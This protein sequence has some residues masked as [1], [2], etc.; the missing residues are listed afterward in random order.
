MQ[1]PFILLCGEDRY[2]GSMFHGRCRRHLLRAGFTLIEL[3]LV[4]GIIAVLAAITISAVNPTKSIGSARDT[5]RK[6]AASEIRKA[7]DQYL[8]ATSALPNSS[9][10]PVGSTLA[11]PICTQGVTTDATCINMDVLAPTYIASIPR[12]STEATANYSG[13]MVYKDSS[14]RP[15]VM[16]A[17]F[18]SAMQSCRQILAADPQAP[19]GRY[20]INLGS[21]TPVYCD[22][23]T[24]GGGWTIVSAITGADGEQPIVSDTEVLTGNPL[25]FAHYN[26]SRAK[27]IALSAVSS[28]TI[29]VRNN[30][31]WLFATSPAF[32]STLSVA[33]SHTD[34]S[35][36]LYANNG[37]TT[38]G[39]MGFSNFGY[40]AGG[41]FGVTLSGFDHHNPGGYN[42]LNAGCANHFLYSYSVNA[43][44]SDAGYKVNTA[45]GTWAATSTCDGSEGGTLV[46]YM[47]MR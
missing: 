11:K 13:Y 47:G 26:I 45:L 15:F 5:A 7:L 34:I 46:F 36:T 42:H 37:V 39:V 32:N 12:D 28:Q 14:E 19:S 18:G 40:A 4:M 6:S 23:T 31:T 8:I 10:I 25:A 22:M 9:S 21:A 17:N 33:N 30:G 41:D 29:F 3:L 44:D 43:Q 20:T 16:A 1:Q 38:S 27:K 2:S 35:T 24:S